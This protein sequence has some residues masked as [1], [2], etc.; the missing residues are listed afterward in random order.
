[1]DGATPAGNAVAAKNLLMLYDFFYEKHFLDQANSILNRASEAVNKYPNA[2]PTLLTALDYNFDR[3]KQVVVV[4]KEGEKL[5]GQLI[6]YFAENFVPNHVLSSIKDGE[7]SNL[8][9]LKD[10]QLIAGKSTVYVCEDHIC[11]LPTSDFEQAKNLIE[12]IE[13]LML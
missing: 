5:R 11:K 3:S 10:K 4:E 9:V 2:F 12:D 13:K 8:P 6:D 1:M 7:K